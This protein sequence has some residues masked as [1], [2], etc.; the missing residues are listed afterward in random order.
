LY[1]EED[2]TSTTID[3]SQT[4]AAGV[5]ESFSTPQKGDRY[6]RAASGDSED[7]LAWSLDTYQ[8][9]TGSIIGLEEDLKNTYIGD[10]SFINTRM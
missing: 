10:P 9:R 7:P 6:T 4:D 8:K 2:E 5:E 3:D 1:P